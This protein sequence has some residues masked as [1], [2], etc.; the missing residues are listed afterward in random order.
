M[1]E[2]EAAAS[3][4]AEADGDGEKEGKQLSPEM[5]RKVAERVWQLWQA[6]LRIERERRGRSRRV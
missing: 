6:D 2:N 4:S 3:P 1:A 5:T